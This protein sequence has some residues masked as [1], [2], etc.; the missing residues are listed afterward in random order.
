MLVWFPKPFLGLSFILLIQVSLRQLHNL[1][2]IRSAFFN[3]YCFLPCL[4]VLARPI[5]G[6]VMRFIFE[7]I[8]SVLI[9][10]KMNI[11]GSS[12]SMKLTRWAMC[13]LSG[14]LFHWR[15]FAYR[16]NWSCDFF[17]GH[18]TF[19]LPSINVIHSLSLA[20]LFSQFR[21]KPTWSRHLCF[22]PCQ[23]PFAEI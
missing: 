10:K 16:M 5:V 20:F 12:G 8:I 17:H 2:L 9:F 21:N 4:I 14:M 23:I 6:C 11:F 3:L 1:W 7:S 22:L 19:L 15:L 18:V 13:V